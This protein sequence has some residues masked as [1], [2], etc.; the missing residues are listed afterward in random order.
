MSGP[1][2]AAIRAAAQRERYFVRAKVLGVSTE[3]AEAELEAVLDEVFDP[4]RIVGGVDPYEVA[5]GRLISGGPAW[6]PSDVVRTALV[7]NFPTAHPDAS[8]HIARAV[9]PGETLAKE[10]GMADSGE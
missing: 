1:F 2:D 7:N 5:W 3:V 8:D 6:R 4:S 10:W 9:A